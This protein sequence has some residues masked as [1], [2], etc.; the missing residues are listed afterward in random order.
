MFL[1]SHCLSFE[2]CV[3]V[4]FLL[5]LQLEFKIQLDFLTKE[6][7]QLF[8][9]HCESFTSYITTLFDRRVNGC[10]GKKKKNAEL[11]GVE[12]I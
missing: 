8:D 4:F 6:E 3:N 1:S 9:V 10:Y 11:A 5:N 7:Q 12:V 2:G